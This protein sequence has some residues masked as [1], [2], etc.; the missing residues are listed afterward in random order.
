M[1]KISSLVI[2]LATFALPMKSVE[3]ASCPDPAITGVGSISVT[4][5]PIDSSCYDY[6]KGG[7]DFS[8]A[9]FALLDKVGALGAN[10][11][12]SGLYDGALTVTESPTGQGTWSIGSIGSYNN[13]ILAVKDGN[14]GDGYQWGAFELA[15]FN[16][17]VI[18]NGTWSIVDAAGG[19]KALSGVELWGSVSAVP[20]PAAVWLFGTALL[21]FIGMSRRTKV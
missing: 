17:S 9:G 12:S 4:T 14:I 16:G 20:V 15:L 13:L 21:G 11:D 3:A 10:T 1:K 5:S 19:A 2:V 8:S 7:V 18:K 6:G